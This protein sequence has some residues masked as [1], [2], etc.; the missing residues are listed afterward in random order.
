MYKQILLFNN[1]TGE[2]GFTTLLNDLGWM[3]SE[4]STGTGI[5]DSFSRYVLVS[6]HKY[7]GNNCSRLTFH[8]Q[9]FVLLVLG[10]YVCS[11]AISMRKHE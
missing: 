3:E 8:I 5:S 4:F 9:P 10:M 11:R 7:F 1:I 6:L 2:D